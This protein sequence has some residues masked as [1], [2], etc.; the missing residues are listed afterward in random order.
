MA[1]HPSRSLARLLM[2]REFVRSA[3][4]EKA[5]LSL[6]KQKPSKKILL[7]LI[8][9]AVSYIIC[10][11]VISALGVFAVYIEQPE[12]VLIGG[13]LIW[14]AAHFL[15]MF[16]TYLAGVEHTKA[17]TKWLARKFV[18]SKLPEEVQRQVNSVA[19]KTE[20]RS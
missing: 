1:L 5:D 11:P 9:I 19:D 4:K 16:G 14:T 7:G 6:F 3:V 15:C 18:E 20:D 10:W 17:L 13:P 8:C 2:R 12:L